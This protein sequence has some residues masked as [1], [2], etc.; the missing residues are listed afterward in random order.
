M[1]IPS[2]EFLVTSGFVQKQYP[3]GLFW[4]LFKHDQLFIQLDESR[5]NITLYNEGWVE[6]NLTQVEMINTI[7][8]FKAT[9]S[10]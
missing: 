3:D 7:Q 5:T 1:S 10:E 6:D 4:L 2:V 8:Q 9:E